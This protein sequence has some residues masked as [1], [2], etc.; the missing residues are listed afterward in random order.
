MKQI[1]ADQVI[2]CGN[3]RAI[4]GNLRS[5]FDFDVALQVTVPIAWRKVLRQLE[6]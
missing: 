1:A 6:L 3:L 2:I 4:C 5:I